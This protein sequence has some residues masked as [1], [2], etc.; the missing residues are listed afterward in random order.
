[1]IRIGI[2]MIPITYI[3][4][5][6]VAFFKCIP[7][8]HQWQINPSP[9][10]KR[11]LQHLKQFKRSWAFKTDVVIDHCMPAVSVLQTIYVMVMNTI[12]D[13]FLMAIPLPVR[14]LT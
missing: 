2:F 3:S 8:N 14:P 13:F 1:M 10:S 12:T 6:L 4:C 11:L 9:G 5:L 7:F